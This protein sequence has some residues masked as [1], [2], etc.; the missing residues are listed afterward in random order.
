M[1]RNKIY[2]IARH[3]WTGHGIKWVWATSIQIWTTDS[4]W[5]FQEGFESVIQIWT[6]GR[7][8]SDPSNSL[9]SVPGRLIKSTFLVNRVKMKRSASQFI[10]FGSR[11]FTIASPSCSW[12]NQEEQFMSTYGKVFT[13][14]PGLATNLNHILGLSSF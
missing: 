9:K 5:K 14:K 12:R 11:N 6:S 1:S 3:S 10:K 8:F 4:K 2:W 7:Q 13:C